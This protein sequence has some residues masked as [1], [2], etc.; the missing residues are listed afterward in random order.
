[1][2]AAKVATMKVGEFHGNQHAERG[3]R[4]L[5]DSSKPLSQPEAAKLLNVSERSVQRATTIRDRGVPELQA[6]VTEGRVSVAA[7]EEIA[8]LP[9]EEQQEIVAKGEKEIVRSLS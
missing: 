2:V 8:R 7:A 9:A 4:Q 5:A 1:M 3:V 6:A